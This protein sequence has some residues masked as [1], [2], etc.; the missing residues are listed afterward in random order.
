MKK[1]FYLN[2]FLIIL[3]FVYIFLFPQSYIPIFI[4]FLLIIIHILY[5]EGTLISKIKNLI[6]SYSQSVSRSFFATFI[7]VLIFLAYSYKYIYWELYLLS[8]LILLNYLF[9]F[10]KSLFIVK[11]VNLKLS[12]T[13]TP[14]YK[15]LED[16]FLGLPLNISY[17]YVRGE[18]YN[19][20]QISKANIDHIKD[21]VHLNYPDIIISTIKKREIKLYKKYLLL[22]SSYNYY[23]D[24]LNILKDNK[25]V[26]FSFILRNPYRFKDLSLVILKVESNDK[27]ILNRVSLLLSNNKAKSILFYN[28]NLSHIFRPIVS[29]N[30]SLNLV[31]HSLELNIPSRVLDKN[32]GV[33]I[34]FNNGKKV[35]IKDIYLK[36]HSYLIGK[37]GSGKSLFMKNIIVQNIKNCKSTI[38]I[39]P[40]NLSDLIVSELSLKDRKNCVLVDFSDIKYSINPLN[41]D[42]NMNKYLLIDNIVSIFK[43]LYPE[44]WGPQSDDILRRSLSALIFSENKYNILDLEEFLTDE[45]FRL[46]VLLTLKDKDTLDYFDS[47]FSKWDNRSRM[48]RISPIINKIGRLKSDKFISKFVSG[49]NKNLDLNSIVD[50]GKSIIFS[51]PKNVVGEENSK[52]LGSLI[53]NQI[54]NTIIQKKSKNHVYLYIDEFQNFISENVLFIFSE[55]RKYNLSVFVA[56]QYI[57]Q[58]DKKYLSSIIENCSNF[59]IMDTGESSRK[60]LSNI[61][62]FEIPSN[63]N[64]YL[65][66]SKNDNNA[67]YTIYSRLLNTYG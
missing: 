55:S 51:I 30:N 16:I 26:S 5:S 27:K 3:L 17:E 33:F 31:K 32:K 44:F 50:K 23:E 22:D 53:I 1:N 2:Q 67:V 64:R 45:H 37:T 39:D 60:Y 4:I 52:F 63:I 9:F 54:R 18:V 66:Y 65:I 21:V 29:S 34:G 19:S 62:N 40:H 12:S 43:D 28:K 10:I 25:S 56:N 58:I 57:D 13:R 8:I 41:L 6:S 59:Y 11:K 24:I 42:P 46:K 49:E 20:V 61:I 35:R 47:I 7:P 36:S 38:V 48:D 15:S 14:H